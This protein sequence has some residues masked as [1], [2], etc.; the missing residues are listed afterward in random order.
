MITKDDILESML[1]ECD[2]V[3]HLA[4]KL[5]AGG[6][7]HRV[8]DDQRSALEILRYLAF[9][10]IGGTRAVIDGNWDAYKA[11]QEK[12]AD[13]TPETFADAIAE[14]KQALTE[15]IGALTDDDLARDATHPLGHTLRVERM[16]I[17]MPLK[18]LVAYRMQ[19]FTTIK[20]AGASDL[21]TP[22]C[23]GGV[24]MERPQPAS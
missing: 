7:D 2:I 6:A 22:D 11:W 12:T 23:W 10:G 1:N 21:W 24:S 14:Q 5:P 8:S 20:A 18:W 15:A 13:V 19:L 16:L 3:V 9:C 17:E 4:S